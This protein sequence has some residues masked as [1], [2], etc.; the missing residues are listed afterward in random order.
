LVL[1][2]GAAGSLDLDATVADGCLMT[3]RGVMPDRGTKAVSPPGTAS[4]PFI[5]LR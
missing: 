4:T 5:G 2:A 3:G 1:A